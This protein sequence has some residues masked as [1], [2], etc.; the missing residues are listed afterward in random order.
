MASGSGRD[1]Q[2]V[3][4]LDL[5]DVDLPE[6]KLEFPG[7]LVFVDVGV[8]PVFRSNSRVAEVPNPKGI[9]RSGL[10]ARMKIQM[11]PVATAKD[12]SRE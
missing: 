3:V 9:L 11:T 7:K 10:P 12:A 8:E 2:V 4:K 5:P 6:E 1:P